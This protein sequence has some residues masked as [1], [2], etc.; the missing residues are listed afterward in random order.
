MRVISAIYFYIVFWLCLE[1]SYTLNMLELTKGNFKLA[2]VVT[3]LAFIQV[4]LLQFFIETT[5]LKVGPSCNVSGFY[6]GVTTSILYRDTW[7][8][9]MTDFLRSFPESLQVHTNII[10]HFLIFIGLNVLM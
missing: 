4:W 3:F 6:S 8:N 7:I 2:Q 9:Y 5:G 1:T 10:F